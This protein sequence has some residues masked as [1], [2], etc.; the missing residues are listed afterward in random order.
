MKPEQLELNE[1]RFAG[2]EKNVGVLKIAGTAW[3]HVGYRQAPYQ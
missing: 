2:A 3:R 1:L